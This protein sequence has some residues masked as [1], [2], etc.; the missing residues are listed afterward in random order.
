MNREPGLLVVGA[1]LAGLRA[2]EAAR[3]DGWDG[4]ITLLGGEP[5]LPYDRPPLS[6]A[7]LNSD[8]PPE[9][10]PFRTEAELVDGLGVTLAL[11]E[12]ATGLDLAGSVVITD[13][14]SLGYS[15]LVIATGSSPLRLPGVALSDRILTLRTWHDAVALHQRLAHGGRLVVVGAGFIGAEIASAAARRG[16]AVTLVEAAEAP[17]VPALGQTVARAVAELHAANGV[18]LT[19]GTKVV[20]VVEGTHTVT[21]NLDDGRALPAETVVVGIGSRP[22]QAW[23]AGS[24]LSLGNGV[25]CDAALAAAPNVYAAGDVASW[26]NPAFDGDVMRLEHWTSAAEQGMWAGRNAVRADDEPF[27][28]VPY[29]WSDWYD[30]RIQFLG[31]YSDDLEIVGNIAEHRFIALYRRGDR[32]VGAMGLNSPAMMRL[33]TAITDRTDFGA[34]RDSLLVGPGAAR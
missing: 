15:R 24:G 27:S 18:N 23:L 22:E 34:V 28:T 31:R 8:S 9:L 5:V 14:R 2:V 11:G 3:R 29:F 4:P 20:S 12:R 13:R 6:K 26:P 25:S 16:L 7:V 1:S 19:T 10:K 32:L 33:R 30:N 17:L 21:I